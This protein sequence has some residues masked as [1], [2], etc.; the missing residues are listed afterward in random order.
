MVMSNRVNF[1]AVVVFICA[2]FSVWGGAHDL[3]AKEYRAGFIYVTPSQDAG[4]SHSHDLGRQALE[5]MPE[6][7]TIFVD[8][9]SEDAHAESVLTHMAGSGYDIVFATSFGYMEAVHRV[10]PNFPGTI[11]MHCS[12]YRRAKNVGVYFGRM[13]E[14]RYLTGLVAGA[15]TRTGVVGYV[16][17]YPLPE[18]IRG[19]NAF[20]LGVREINPKASVHVRWVKSWHDADRETQL[21]NEL[22]NGKADVLAQHLDSPATQ[23]V[24]QKR[25]VYSV[26]YS[27]DMSAFAPQAHLTAAVWHWEAIYE[28]TM[29]RVMEGRWTSEPI[30]WGLDRGVVDIGAFGPMVD[31]KI[32]DLVLSRR[33]LIAEGRHFVFAGP[34]KDQK[35]AV[36]IAAGARPGDE[37]LLGMNWFVHGV[38]GSPNPE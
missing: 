26:G 27:Q 28:Y 22:V 6:V 12:G 17:A 24:A 10:A 7:T 29:K 31:K 8:S 34:V 37:E 15:M 30:W 38:A 36:R 18:V 5:K 25:G 35:G 3:W 1:R 32:R 11:F 33:K 2:F 20:T 16:A 23:I 19:I 4:W 13:Y 9:I 21:A 14:A